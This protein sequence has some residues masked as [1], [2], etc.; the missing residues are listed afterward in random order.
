MTGEAGGENS[1]S[2]V[3][4]GG[5]E[6]RIAQF[7]ADD[8]QIRAAMPKPD[9]VEAAR[10]PGLRLPQVLQT[11]VEGY[12]DRP[13]LRWRA[14]TLTTDPTTGRTTSQL[15]SRFETITYRDLWANLRAAAAAWRLDPDHPVAPGDFVATVG[16]GPST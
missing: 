4:G 3:P 8:E 13:A 5:L 12:A 16:F 11:Y 15:L 10:R 14:L 7:C 1:T 6:K 9:V 2:P